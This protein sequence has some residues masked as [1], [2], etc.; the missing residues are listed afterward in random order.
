MSQSSIDSVLKESRVFDPPEAFSKN[1][2]IKSMADYERIC[3]EAEADPEKFWG[4]IAGELHWFRQW[5]KVLEW[6]PPWAKWFV[7]GQLNLSYNCLDR[8]V[9]TWRRNKAAIIWEGE[10][11]DKRKHSLISNFSQK[12]QGLLTS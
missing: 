9:A 3:S 11:G 4:G 7:G 6:D 1:A 10:P 12:S 2:H 5:D 8:H